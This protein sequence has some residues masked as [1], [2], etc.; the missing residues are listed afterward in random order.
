M[1][2]PPAGKLDMITILPV[3]H[4]MIQCHAPAVIL[5]TAKVKKLIASSATKSILQELPS[6]EWPDL[7]S[8]DSLSGA[9][10]S[11]ARTPP[12]A[13]ETAFIE[14]TVSPAGVL[15]GV[16][17]SFG[18]L[19]LACTALCD[20]LGVASG[21][22][23]AVL[24]RPLS[25]SYFLAWVFLPV[26]MGCT[27]THLPLTS[28]SVP[29]VFATIAARQ[30]TTALVSATTV[31][32]M[33]PRIAH[34]LETAAPTALQRL[35]LVSR[36]RPLASL[37]SRL[38]NL[39]RPAGTKLCISLDHRCNSFV[40]IGCGGGGGG[41]PPVVHACATQLR[42]G[43]VVSVERG[44]ANS[45][46]LES[47]GR[48]P[49]GCKLAVVEPESAVR[50]SDPC[51]VGEVWVHAPWNRAGYA[52]LTKQL[53]SQLDREH[54]F[55]PLDDG[56]QYAR[57]GRCLPNVPHLPSSLPP[58]PLAPLF[59][60]FFLSFFLSVCLSACLCL[61]VCLC[62]CLA[63]FCGTPQLPE[64]PAFSCR[65]CELS[66]PKQ[67]V[68]TKRRRHAHHQ[69]SALLGWDCCVKRPQV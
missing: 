3:V 64:P 54:F 35:V 4:A 34:V 41:R 12:T 36:D 50:C 52:G 24:N 8:T 5:T 6:I 28:A 33:M 29:R 56:L 23:F 60:S 19:V 47:H 31:A 20:A 21:E 39:L 53:N 10:K 61:S 38:S 57:S 17:V 59:L 1:A 55:C 68:R 58:G 27:C 42:A 16:R 11:E 67:V 49:P 45:T 43:R 51:E 63:L 44:S 26:V 9:K 40:S 62:M 13:G 65:S 15:A 14:Y 25:G 7:V 37:L 46:A 2:Q 22:K 30:I 66:Y 18:E 48:P 32:G 69:K